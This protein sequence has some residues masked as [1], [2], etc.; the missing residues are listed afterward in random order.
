MMTSNYFKILVMTAALMAGVLA[1]ILA[2]ESAG[3]AFPGTNGKLAFDSFLPGQADSEIVTLSYNP[4]GGAV[5]E[6]P[7]PPLTDNTTSD[8]GAAW[9]PDGSKI[10]FEKNSEIY[11]M[12]SNGAK[13]TRL[14][15]NAFIDSN[16]TW[17]PD[18]SQLAVVSESDGDLDIWTLKPVPEGPANV[19]Q[20]LT[21][22]SGSGAF[23]SDPSWSPY[24]P[25]G[26]TSVAFHRNG[27]VWIVDPANPA[28]KTQITTEPTG[29]DS[30]PNW[31]PKGTRIAFQS[32]RNTTAF[33]N[34]GADQEIYTIKAQ[35]ENATTNEPRRLTDNTVRDESPAWSAEGSHIAFMSTRRDN[36]LEIWVMS[37]LS[38]DNAVR[39]T[40]NRGID[41]YPDWQPV[42]V[43][44]KT[45]TTGNDKLT[46][47]TGKDILCGGAGNDVLIGR[48]GND[49]LLGESGNDS[50]QGG[51]GNDIHNGGTG[52][53]TASYA[54]S[55]TPVTA[56][57]ATDFATG[58]GSDLLSYIERLTGSTKADNLTVADT[59][60]STTPSTNAAN[61]LKGLGGAD[62]L[63][64]AEGTGNDRVDGGTGLDDC[65]TDAGD[66]KLNCP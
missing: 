33:P 48:G 53:D 4:N 58:E 64:A 61:V 16:P 27:D 62:T 29:S 31:S 38:D 3:A 57:L 6:D 37:T 9:S 7:D 28:S 41:E 59:D 66:T 47:T 2:E 56:S 21:D 63:D 17:S 36:N 25:D 18:G 24:L 14:T 65:Q 12:N 54:S 35:P 22:D 46:G 8:S 42:P 32:N 43:C 45:G 34:A 52:T 26:S 20:N 11:V 19:R 51:T 5:P 44:T 60:T 40:N 10:A 1:L 30:F 23:D 15:N 50:L 49:I 55:T 13:Q 39:L